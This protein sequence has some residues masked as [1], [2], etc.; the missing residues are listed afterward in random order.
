VSAQLR[1]ERALRLLPAVE[2][3]EPLR[4]LLLSVAQTDDARRWSS[5]GPYETVGK[6]ALDVE[7]LRRRVDALLPRVAAHVTTLFG[8][9]VRALQATEDGDGTA[10]ALA[11]AD[12]GDEE[13]ASRRLIQAQAWYD[14][15][16]RI[17][18][19]LSDRRAEI[20]I[21]ARL[22]DVSLALD[23]PADAGRYF[24]RLL[25]L[26]EAG[27]DHE[28]VIRACLGL[29]QAALAR[30]QNDGARAWSLRG[31]RQAAGGNYPHR[32]VQL[33]HAMSVAAWRSG[34]IDDA[35]ERLG[36]ARDMG[37]ALDAPAE[38]ARI[39]LTRG[40]I[41][42]DLRKPADSVATLREALAWAR[43][44]SEPALRVEVAVALAEAH[45]SAGHLVDAERELRGAEQFAIEERAADGL[46][47][48]YIAMGK[49]C[50]I[51]NDETG[52]V[53]FEQAI[54]LCRM[55]AASAVVEG[56]ASE[57]Y[58]RFRQRFGQRDEAHAHFERSARL[59]ESAHDEV[60]LRRL[61]DQ[62][63]SVSA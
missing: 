7:S 27:F 45:V 20:D 9:Y 14:V 55:T 5:S 30:H 46:V 28:S 44:T 25:V 4:A 8:A 58:G 36:R 24:Q 47:S 52:F 12:A 18:T 51:K 37:E 48:V 10:A 61:K 16:F 43:R 50:A 63:D 49:L 56:R 42:R 11:L 40:Y 59:F 39:L 1:V 3:L 2:A 33:E 60:S 54:E 29:C 22:G 26:A 31:L 34:D 41:E 57:E 53:F 32:T 21:L 62:L 6:R 35:R 23:R 15:A 13:R 38:M 19:E 17:A